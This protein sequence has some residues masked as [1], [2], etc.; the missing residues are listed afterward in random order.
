ML[1]IHIP[2]AGV[3]AQDEMAEVEDVGQ[4]SCSRMKSQRTTH[5]QTVP[6]TAA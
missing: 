1:S 3:V 2:V 4:L 6:A 5:S